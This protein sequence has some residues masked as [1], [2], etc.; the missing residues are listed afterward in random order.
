[1]PKVPL[2]VIANTNKI[3]APDFCPYFTKDVV[4]WEDIIGNTQGS[5]LPIPKKYIN[6]ISPIICSVCKICTFV[7]SIDTSLELELSVQEKDKC[8]EY[9]TNFNGKLSKI[10][11]RQISYLLNKERSPLAILITANTLQNMLEYVIENKKRR[12]ALFHYF[13]EEESSLCSIHGC[14]V[15]FSRKLTL[16]IIQVVGEVE[17]K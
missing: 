11:N 2:V 5:T 6:T 4:E 10:I 3:E 15:Y 7:P 8:K 1:M 17:W 14:P 16:S 13:I 12:D 9:L